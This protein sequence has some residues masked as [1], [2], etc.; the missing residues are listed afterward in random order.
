MDEHPKSLARDAL[1][2]AV[3]R[4]G[5]ADAIGSYDADLDVITWLHRIEPPGVK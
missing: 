2:A 5:G 4:I 3:C 1:H